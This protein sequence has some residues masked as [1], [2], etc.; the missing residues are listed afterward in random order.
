MMRRLSEDDLTMI[1]ATAE[2]APSLPWLYYSQ[3]QCCEGECISTDS[4]Q[5]IIHDAS[6]HSDS[7][8]FL[9]TA[10]GDILDLIREVRVLKL[11]LKLAIEVQEAL[12]REYSEDDYSG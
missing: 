10:R 12:V 3:G 9:T 2:R 11:S 1:Q 8:E 7:I 4:G 6:I 5:G